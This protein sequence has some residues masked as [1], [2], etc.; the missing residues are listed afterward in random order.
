MNHQRLDTHRMA[1]GQTRGNTPTLAVD[2]PPRVTQTKSVNHGLCDTH[3][4]A[5]TPAQVDTPMK[6][7]NHSSVDIHGIRVTLMYADTHLY[8]GSQGELVT[9]ECD[10]SHSG[11]DTLSTTVDHYKPDAQ[12]KRVSYCLGNTPPPS[13]IPWTKDIH[14][15]VETL[16]PTVSHKKEGNHANIDTSPRRVNP[17]VKDTQ[18]WLVEAA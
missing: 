6:E 14:L 8:G 16:T 15:C 12:D 17:V 5:V 3:R 10:A 4:R 7:G 9:Q 11:R 2:H 1:V 13:M 18:N